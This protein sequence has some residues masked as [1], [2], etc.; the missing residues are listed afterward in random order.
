ME[1]YTFK[2]KNATLFK[3]ML[4]VLVYRTVKDMNR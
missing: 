4:N 2:L 3:N 1:K